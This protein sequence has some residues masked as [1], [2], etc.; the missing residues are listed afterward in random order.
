MSLSLILALIGSATGLLVGI[1]AFGEIS[2]SVECP[3]SGTGGAGVLF[4][5]TGATSD[6]LYTQGPASGVDNWLGQLVAT[7]G[8]QVTAI[9]VNDYQNNVNTGSALTAEIRTGATT[10][11]DGST[12]VATSDNS[13]LLTTF[14]TY[15]FTFTFTPPV[16]VNDPDTYF[17]LRGS[18]GWDSDN[19]VETSSVDLSQ[20]EGIFWVHDVPTNASFF[21]PL[22]F[23]DMLMKVEI[24]GG[25]S[26]TVG[27]EECESAKDIAWSV[28]GILPVAL[29]FGLFTLFNFTIGKQ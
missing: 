26:A 25:G 10:D 7:N 2:D 27:E 3:T 9:I 21:A 4:D 12:L 28:I 29:F 23:A 19:L 1:F 18:A 5:T 11:I 17:A 6:G 22:G 20:G 16:T 15:D 14:G 8:E 13:E 24:V